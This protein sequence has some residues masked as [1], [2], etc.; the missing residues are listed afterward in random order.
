[1]VRKATRGRCVRKKAND[2]L[3]TFGSVVTSVAS[4][5]VVTFIAAS[6][7][8]VTVDLL[9]TISKDD[10]IVLDGTGDKKGIEERCELIRSAIE[11]STSDYDKDKFQEGLA[12]LSGGVAVSKVAMFCLSKWCHLWLSNSFEEICE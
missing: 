1:M 11:L 8:V 10:N 12:K 7:F 4:A 3:L 2:L 9:A 6:A 5:S